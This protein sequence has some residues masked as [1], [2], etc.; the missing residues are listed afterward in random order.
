MLSTISKSDLIVVS[1]HG[2]FNLRISPHCKLFIADKRV[3]L[4]Q[5]D[6]AALSIDFDA[7]KLFDHTH[8][9]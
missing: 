8:V 1:P 6:S 4:L 5:T 3:V 9:I 2:E 7:P